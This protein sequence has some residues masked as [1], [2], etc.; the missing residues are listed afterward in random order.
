MVGRMQGERAFAVMISVVH[1]MDHLMKRLFPPLVPL[2]GLLYGFP[3]WQMGLVM[4][5]LSFGG[6]IG[7]APMGI[8]SDRYD[9]RY[10]LPV[11]I[12]LSGL[13][14]VGFSLTPGVSTTEVSI[15]GTQ[16]SGTVLAMTV[17]T[18]AI[19][20]GS[21]TVHPTGYPLITA[22][23]DERRKGR[24]L[25]SW[26]AAAKFGD[27]L[28]PAFVGAL[29]LFLAWPNVV[30][31]FGAI[32]LLYAV[33]LYVSLGSFETRPGRTHG[34]DD[35]E[36]DA[37]PD[38]AATNGGTTPRRVYV[39]PLVVVFCYFV[40]HLM[41]AE[42]VSVFMPEFIASVYGYSGTVIGIELTPESTASFYYA[43]LL[44]TAGAAQLGSG[45]LVDRY[46]P[47]LILLGFMGVS[48]VMLALV[49]LTLLP[50][51][52]LLVALLVAGVG[53]WG[54]NPA[55]D[56]IIS[57]IAPPEY[58]GRAFGYLWTGALLAMSVA[59]P[60]IGYVGDQF[61]LRRAFIVLAG[62][63]VLATIPLLVLP[64]LRAD[65]GAEPSPSTAR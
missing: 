39:I 45:R 44:L 47:R 31:M 56:A 42:G 51:I 14:V 37:T 41:A 28:A 34:D 18:F 63:I 32:G 61:G 64:Y 38:P 55:R 10:I 24:V 52:T 16:L 5:S 4:G 33:F 6:A 30:A 15:F 54:V 7:Q 46:D 11:G 43:V 19:G 60:I 57:D 2:W 48:A 13:A 58:E 49:S 29:T 50:P 40:V 1:G 59:P 25:G 17:A 27:G 23:V 3:L 26:G 9:R 20:I 65:D 35:P 8:L 53:L 21:S 36:D 22:N 12:G 62:A